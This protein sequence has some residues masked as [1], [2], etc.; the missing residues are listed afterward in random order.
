MDCSGKKFV[1]VAGEVF[2]IE[3]SSKI[4]NRR[5]RALFCTNPD[6]ISKTWTL[7]YR[8]NPSCACPKPLL[9]TMY[10]VKVYHAENVNAFIFKCDEK[11]F[12]KWVWHFLNRISQL[13]FV[14]ALFHFFNQNLSLEINQY[15][16]T[17]IVV[18]LEGK[19]ECSCSILIW[20]SVCTSWWY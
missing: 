15:I 16:N 6:V 17:L 7:L 8:K 11:S 1:Q 3:N 12:R 10:F 9:W 20:T 19:N 2:H 18:W 13:K 4:I 14:S 5:S